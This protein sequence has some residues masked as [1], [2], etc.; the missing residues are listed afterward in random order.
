[1]SKSY[2]YAIHNRRADEDDELGSCICDGFDRAQVIE[3]ATDYFEG[4]AIEGGRYGKGEADVLLSKSDDDGEEEIEEIKLE[5][6]AERGTY[7]GGRFDYL[8]G[9]GAIRSF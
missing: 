9:I 1:M 5:W 3:A 8:A 4:K 2:V 6:D 7:D